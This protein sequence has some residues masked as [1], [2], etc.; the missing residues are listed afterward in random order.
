MYSCLYHAHH[1]CTSEYNHIYSCQ[2]PR[3]GFTQVIRIRMATV[4]PFLSSTIDKKDVVFTSKLVVF[5][6]TRTHLCKS[7]RGLRVR[8]A[9]HSFHNSLEFRFGTVADHFLLVGAKEPTSALEKRDGK[10]TRS[11]NV[12]F[13]RVSPN[14]CIR[15]PCGTADALPGT[16]N[17]SLSHSLYGLVTLVLRSLKTVFISTDGFLLQDPAVSA[18]QNGSTCPVLVS[19]PE[20]CY[21]GISIGNRFFSCWRQVRER[22]TARNRV[23]W[24]D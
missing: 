7:R 24:R 6:L 4:A 1:Q 3:S 5:R 13:V 16:V 22:T 12:C 23:C 20:G 11:S 9:W 10:W 15:C 19:R 14:I 2:S 8:F 21:R 18:E 17:L